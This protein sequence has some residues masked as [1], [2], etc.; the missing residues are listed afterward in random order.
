VLRGLH[1]HDR[2]HHVHR[3][4][5]MRLLVCDQHVPQRHTWHAMHG[6][7]RHPTVLAVAVATAS[8]ATAHSAA[9]GA[10]AG[11]S[12]ATTPVVPATSSATCDATAALA[13]AAADGALHWRGP[14][15]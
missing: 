15:L 2:S 10:T 14:L 13:P 7:V 4:E 3:Q 6:H 11:T 9:A 1:R 12:L 5:G 8:F